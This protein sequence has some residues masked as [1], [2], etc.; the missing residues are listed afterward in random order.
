[1]NEPF[2]A[3]LSRA[4]K[5]SSAKVLQG[6]EFTPA[7]QQKVLDRLNEEEALTPVRPA[8][9]FDP[10]QV[11]RPLGWIAVAAAAVFLVFN[12]GIGGMGSPKK[13]SATDFKT[14]DSATPM[15]PTATK[16][17][18]PQESAPPTGAAKQDAGAAASNDQKAAA[19]TTTP[20]TTADAPAGAA[21]PQEAT[22]TVAA[23]PGPQSPAPNYPA[24]NVVALLPPREAAALK[25]GPRSSGQDPAPTPGPALG[26]ASVT[27]NVAFGVVPGDG[28]VVLST[29]G[30]RNQQ[31]DGALNWSKNVEGL[32]DQS[33]VAVSN[34]GRIAVAN[35]DRRLTVYNSHGD[36]EATIKLTAPAEKMV[37]SDDGRLATAEE[38]TYVYNGSK[39]EF[40]GLKARNRS[41]AFGPDGTL[42][43]FGE[44]SDRGAVLGLYD[45]RGKETLLTV[46]D[47]GSGLAFAGDGKVVV[48][49][50][51]AFDRSGKQ[52]WRMNIKPL[53]L[54]RLGSSQ[55]VA[56]DATN[57]LG[58]RPDGSYA[59]QATWTSGGAAIK[60]VVASPDGRYAAVV[61]AS[62]KETLLWVLDADGWQKH[63]EK[64]PEVPLDLAFSGDQLMILTPSEVLTRSITP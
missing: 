31:L 62:E 10:G 27:S 39:T 1:M 30:I 42:A 51:V 43:V 15:A 53:G 35:A 2:D 52:L 28:A 44:Q 11:I 19:P 41:M 60:K 26:T 12:V 22:M 46:A 25:A 63:A 20:T 5:E 16:P 57:V 24:M 56:W 21:T 6:W 4:F 32:G 48:A 40:F 17:A 45:R 50:G 61:A 3:E 33:L 13:E 7:M 37:W 64:L 47:A 36:V 29:D 8:R 38:L 54:T 58:V 55:I 34:D 59:W 49:G 18:S 9:R 14:A 23:P